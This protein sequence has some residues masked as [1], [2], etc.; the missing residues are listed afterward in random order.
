VLVAATIAAGRSLFP[1]TRQETLSESVL[2][3]RGL[4]MKH[5]VGFDD[6]LRTA[7]ASNVPIHVAWCLGHCALMMHQAAERVDGKLVIADG[8]LAEQTDG[9]TRRFGLGSIAAD[10]DTAGLHAVFPTFQRCVDVFSAAADRLAAAIVVCPNDRLDDQ[11]SLSGGIAQP[12][13]SV[14]P[15]AIFR[16]GMQCGRIADLRQALKMRPVLW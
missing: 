6:D 1:L 4:M 12:R 16:N 10:P 5:I 3:S 13:W 7:T 14:V 2:Q 8:F 15:R 11:V 9:D